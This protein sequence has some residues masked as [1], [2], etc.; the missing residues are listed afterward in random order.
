MTNQAVKLLVIASIVL[1]LDVAALAQDVDAG[2]S[3]FRSSCATCHGIDGKGKGP[4]S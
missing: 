2:K 4:F 1:G 3:E